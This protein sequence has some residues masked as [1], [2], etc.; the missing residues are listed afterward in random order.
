MNHRATVR[1]VN[2]SIGQTAIRLE[3]SGQGGV[4]ATLKQS[5]ADP[6]MLLLEGNQKASF[7]GGWA[8]FEP[9]DRTVHF[10]GPGLNFTVYLPPIEDPVARRA[11]ANLSANLGALRTSRGEEQLS[12]LSPQQRTLWT[13]PWTYSSGTWIRGDTPP[14]VGNSSSVLN[15]EAIGTWIKGDAPPAFGDRS[16]KGNAMVKDLLDTEGR[17]H[18][19]AVFAF[20]GRFGET[21]VL[22]VFA[23]RSFPWD[24]QGQEIALTEARAM[25]EQMEIP[26][27][28]RDLGSKG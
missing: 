20:S 26:V 3:E 7:Q 5:G 2:F 22:L 19:K 17:S 4:T 15:A 27:V 25:V 18:G 9:G 13:A 6:T 24:S 12:H 8:T 21:P 10:E 16:W 28:I 23:H 14:T 1:G 11:G